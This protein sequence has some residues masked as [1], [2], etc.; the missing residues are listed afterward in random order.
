[1]EVDVQEE[2]NVEGPSVEESAD[3]VPEAEPTAPT[4]FD[5]LCK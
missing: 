2:P 5:L 3:A 4:D 1:M